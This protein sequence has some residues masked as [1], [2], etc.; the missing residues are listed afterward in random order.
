MQR[1]YLPTNLCP[2]SFTSRSEQL[3]RAACAA[4]WYAMQAVEAVLA[5][6]PEGSS[7]AGLDSMNSHA[8]ADA[9]RAA[10]SCCPELACE[11]G[12][13]DCFMAHCEVRHV[14]CS[15]DLKD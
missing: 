15:L 7:A 4:H 1:A 14:A 13:L 10:A 11:P 3:V 6:A 5:A 2:C 8:A 12:F 9:L